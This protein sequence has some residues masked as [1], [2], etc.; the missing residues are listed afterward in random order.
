MRQEEEPAPTT[1]PLVAATAAL[2][3]TDTS[4]VPPAPMPAA[5]VPLPETR[6]WVKHRDGPQA[7]GAL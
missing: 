3:L 7:S 4:V 5:P 6:S 2:A 1:E